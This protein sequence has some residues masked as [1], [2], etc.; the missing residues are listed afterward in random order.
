MVSMYRGLGPVLDCV[1]IRNL[2]GSHAISVSIADR[3]AHEGNFLTVMPVL[4]PGLVSP[5]YARQRHPCRSVG[6][7]IF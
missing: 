4:F 1:T 2:A 3:Y 6:H 5:S 7:L